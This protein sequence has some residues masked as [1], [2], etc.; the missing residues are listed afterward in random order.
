MFAGDVEMNQLSVLHMVSA[1]QVCNL[2]GEGDRSS[3]VV[4]V[5]CYK[6]EGCWFDPSWCQWNF[7]L[8]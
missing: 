5:L 4:K 6:S 8:T 1:L 3:S 7:S 2:H